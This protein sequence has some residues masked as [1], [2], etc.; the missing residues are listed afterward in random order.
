MITSLQQYFNVLKFSDLNKIQLV[1]VCVLG[2]HKRKTQEEPAPPYQRSN[3]SHPGP[4]TTIQQTAKRPRLHPVTLNRSGSQGSD[5]E[6]N[7]PSDMDREAMFT[8]T[9]VSGPTQSR[10]GNL[11][12]NLAG[13]PKSLPSESPS[14]MK[15][16]QLGAMLGDNEE[17]SDMA[18]DLMVPTT[19]PS[20]IGLSHTQTSA[21]DSEQGD[22]E[23]T[24]AGDTSQEGASIKVEPN[25]E[26]ELDLEITGVEAGDNSS[27]MSGENW[28]QNVSGFGPGDVGDGSFDQSGS[29]AGYSE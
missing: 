22:K 29:Q 7:L 26:P 4:R 28:G 11:S 18:T 25:T 9:P 17:S 1:C 2:H 6:G 19:L 15:Q 23:Q 20:S 3:I 14:M 12:D 24:D 5:L 21:G 10:K 16:E 27:Q 13:P 8:S